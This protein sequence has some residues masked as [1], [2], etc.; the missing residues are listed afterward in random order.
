M[1]KL[2]PAGY[3]REFK[4][5]KCKECGEKDL[6]MM[7]ETKVDGVFCRKCLSFEKVSIHEITKRID[8]MIEKE[9]N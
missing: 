6:M 8:R 2:S 9:G 3:T 1:P 5:L 4:K 7:G